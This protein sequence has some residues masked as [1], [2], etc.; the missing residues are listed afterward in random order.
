[1]Y[2]IATG[3]P[4]TVVVRLPDELEQQLRDMALRTGTTVSTCVR[5]ACTAYLVDQQSAPVSDASVAY[6]LGS[7]Q[8]GCVASGQHDRSAQRHVLVAASMRAKHARRSTRSA[9]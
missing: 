5:E 3:A 9:R 4:M 2:Y 7:E 6:L 1:M 8:F